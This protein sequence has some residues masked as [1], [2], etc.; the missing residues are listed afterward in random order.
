MI[1]ATAVSPR[2]PQFQR[3]V[4]WKG[5]PMMLLP[6][7]MLASPLAASVIDP[8]LP[9]SAVLQPARMLRDNDVAGLFRLLPAELQLQAEA[10]WQRVQADPWADGR[11]EVDAVLIELF[12]TDPVDHLMSRIA[13]ALKTV[14][15][16]QVSRLLKTMAESIPS[17]LSQTRRDGQPEPHDAHTD[18][19]ILQLQNLLTDASTWVLSVGLQD[20]QKLHD[21]CVHLVAAAEAL[22]VPDTKTLHALP[23]SEVLVRLG[24]VVKKLKDGFTVYQID[25]DRLLDSISARSSGDGDQRVLAVGFTAFGRAYEMPVQ[26]QIRNGTWMVSAGSVESTLF[27][28]MFTDR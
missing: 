28:R 2:G 10:H 3:A 24:P 5:I 27:V 6:L 12:A 7:L 1:P 21:A 16:Q 4:P 11:R 8:S 25:L 18:R 22:N 20:P 15:P 13:P 19:A 14:D 9:E 17:M 23:L 26:V